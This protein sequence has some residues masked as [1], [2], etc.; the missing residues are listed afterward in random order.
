M[1]KVYRKAIL[2][3]CDRLLDSLPNTFRKVV[4]EKTIWGKV[5]SL[6]SLF[7]SPIGVGG[8]WVAVRL[9]PKDG[10]FIFPAV[11]WTKSGGFLEQA[12]G[13]FIDPQSMR[14]P[15]GDEELSTH[16]ARAQ[17]Y[18]YL[19]ELSQRLAWYK[20][21]TLTNSIDWN[22]GRPITELAS[23]QVEIF[24]REA[25]LTCTDA[26]LIV[27]PVADEILTDFSKFGLPLVEKMER[28]LRLEERIGQSAI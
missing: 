25:K 2:E 26:K 18:Y 9:D 13:S 5:G 8:V 7:R 6:L 12:P 16:L 19:H 28:T 11:G 15:E 20:V 14:P 21:P 24:G 23:L 1:N 17:G 22:E 10:D 3:S 4:S 27:K